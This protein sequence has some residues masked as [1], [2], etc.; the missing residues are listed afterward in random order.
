MNLSGIPEVI[1]HLSY[2]KLNA[3][4]YHRSPGTVRKRLRPDTVTILVIGGLDV[5][6]ESDVSQEP[7]N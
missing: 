7:T 3:I 1:Q 4:T 6:R 2:L 5:G